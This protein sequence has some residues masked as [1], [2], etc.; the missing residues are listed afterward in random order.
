MNG[1][2]SGGYLAGVADELVRR[3][4]RRLCVVLL[5]EPTA[6]VVGIY[7]CCRPHEVGT[8]A[9]RAYLNERC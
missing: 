7:T 3:E 5:G 8:S 2:V 6:T 9:A 1:V 4:L